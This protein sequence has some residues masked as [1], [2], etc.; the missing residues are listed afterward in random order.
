MTDEGL[1]TLTAA[2]L[3]ELMRRREVSPVEVVEA[4]LGRI[5]RLNPNINAVVA[6]APDALERAREAEAALMSGEAKGSLCGVPLTVKDTIEA[7]GMRATSGSKARAGYAPGRDAPAVGRLRAAGAIVLGKTNASELALDYTTDNPV[8][9]RTSNPHDP[10]RTPGGS[11]GGC[12]A[13]VAARLA[14]GSLGSD[15]AGSVRIPAH[16]CGVAGLKPTAG[17]VPGAGHF[18][19]LGGA[20]A[21][22]A[23]LGPLARGVEDLSLFFQAL[24]GGAYRHAPEEWAE[25]LRAS[26]LLQGGAS[27][28]FYTDDGV[29]PVGAE[30]REA[31]VRA[32]SALGGA[33]LNVVEERPPSVERATEIWLGLF[34]HATRRMVCGT[35][36]GR[37]EDA[38]PAARAVIKRASREEPTSL[39]AFMDAWD[40]RDRLRASL[41]RWMET[42]PLIVAPVGALAAF[43]H[44]EGR[45][46][47]VGGREL[48]LFDAFGY[49]QA[50]NVFDLPAACVPAGRTAEGMPV[51]V[52]IV[53]R[54][55]EERRVLRAAR[56][57]EEALG[58]GVSAPEALPNRGANPI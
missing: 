17:R 32:A 46:F 29:V 14:A 1:T 7:R 58:G 36:E 43:G 40:E 10:S 11:S 41:L 22:G 53:G 42:R 13:A 5:E 2:R 57:V 9:G 38:G 23:S 18:P 45:R 20:Y 35:Y 8:F 12:A 16:F 37:E 52:Q 25:P 15:L 21:L 39:D 6:L 26:K 55:F 34:S 48:G 47:T 24:S 27:V 4:H 19:L 51:G 54:P 56:V 28:A 50:F 49:A 3:A 33:G 31:V 44:E 30:S